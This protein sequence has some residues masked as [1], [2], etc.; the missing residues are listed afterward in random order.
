[1]PTLPHADEGSQG[2]QGGFGIDCEGVYWESN[3]AADN[4]PLGDNLGSGKTERS[5]PDI[6]DVSTWVGS[7]EDEKQHAVGLIG[8]FRSSEE[9]AKFINLLRNRTP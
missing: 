9:V 2:G 8:W 3:G 4:S 1:M 6:A 7:S 5:N